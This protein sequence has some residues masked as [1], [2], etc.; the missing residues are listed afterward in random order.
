[1]FLVKWATCMDDRSWPHKRVKLPLVSWNKGK[2][3]IGTEETRHLSSKLLVRKRIDEIWGG[4]IQK[5]RKRSSARSTLVRMCPCPCQS[6]WAE[7]LTNTCSRA[8]EH[9]DATLLDAEASIFFCMIGLL[10]SLYQLTLL[11]NLRLLSKRLNCEKRNRSISGSRTRRRNCVI[12]IHQNRDSERQGERR[13]MFFMILSTRLCIL[14]PN[15][16]TSLRVSWAVTVWW[17]VLSW[18]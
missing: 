18:T 1:M 6:Q 2:M 5:A 7:D 15:T 13:D 4:Q 14:E 3:Q 12:W 9:L 16:R 17:E 10:A 11:L 8:F